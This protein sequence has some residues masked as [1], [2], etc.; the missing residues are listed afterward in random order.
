MNTDTYYE[1]SAISTRS[2]TEAKLYTL[3]LVMAVAFFVV[4]GFILTFAFTYVPLVLQETVDEA[5]AV[6]TPARVYSFLTYFGP[7]VLIAL[8][9]LAFWLIKNRFNVSY[10]YTFVED[11]LRVSRVYNGKR[12]KFLKG[13]KTDQMLKLGKCEN[14]SFER[15]CA[16]LDK[17]SVR[18]L[19]P[20]RN[21]GA[22][23]DF[24]YFLYSSSLE[25]AVYILESRVDLIE[26][27]VRTAGRNKWEAK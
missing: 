8:A 24:Y 2:Q 18:F 12:R 1:E 7:I 4:A 22:G 27:L 6:N 13:F 10:D 21:P 3:F 23:K 14:D 9:G 19:T 20:N 15:T 25:K 11:E 16:G 17:K 26:I 5:G